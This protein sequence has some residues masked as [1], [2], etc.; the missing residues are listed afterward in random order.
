MENSTTRMFSGDVVWD[1][2]FPARRIKSIYA[3]SHLRPEYYK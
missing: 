1:P 3:L 2:D